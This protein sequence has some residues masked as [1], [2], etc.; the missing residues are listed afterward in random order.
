MWANMGLAGVLKVDLALPSAV[1]AGHSHHLDRGSPG[2]ARNPEAERPEPD[3]A[4]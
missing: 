1:C 4:C 2:V 3:L